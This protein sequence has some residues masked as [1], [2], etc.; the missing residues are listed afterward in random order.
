M[1]LPQNVASADVVSVQT[2][3]E[4]SHK[5]DVREERV[6]RQARDRE[7]RYRLYGLG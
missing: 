6:F 2:T 4:E 5:S 7:H 1:F 3:L